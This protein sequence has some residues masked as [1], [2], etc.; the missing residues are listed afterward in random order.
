[1]Q[2][3]LIDLAFDAVTAVES[4]DINGLAKCLRK[5]LPASLLTKGCDSL[6]AAA[7]WRKNEEMVLFLLSRE[8]RLGNHVNLKGYSLLETISINLPRIFP[9]V[10]QIMVDGG[11]AP[12]F[13]PYGE[14]GPNLLEAYLGWKPGRER[15]VR[16]ALEAITSKKMQPTPWGPPCVRWETIEAIEHPLFGLV[17]REGTIL[18]AE[19]FAL[20]RD[21]IDGLE[22]KN[23]GDIS[24]R[25]IRYSVPTLCR[26]RALSE[27]DRATRARNCDASSAT[28]YGRDFPIKA[29]L[30]WRL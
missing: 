4:G 28:E 22:E 18:T 17:I 9:G 29:P 10:L 11:C 15:K 21:R 3:L 6:A 16:S 14:N 8:P 7:V 1:M 5:G 19:L 20:Y 2:E 30:T 27:E 26:H 24:I 13:V 25:D 12:N 23:L